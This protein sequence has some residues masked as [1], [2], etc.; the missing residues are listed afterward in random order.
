MATA[1]GN[2]PMDNSSLAN[3]QAWTTPI[4]NAFIAFGWLQT[5]DTGQAANP[6]AAVPS[7]AYAYWVFQ[8]ND[9]QAATSPIFVKV[10]IG[11]SATSPRIR[12]TV[13]TASNGSGTIT[14]Q[15]VSS[16]PWD[17]CAPSSYSS[18][19]A[20]QGGV[21]FP[22]YF[23]GD[24]GEFRMYI[25]QSTTIYSGLLF[26]IERSKDS[27]GNKTAEYFTVLAVASASYAASTAF[28]AQQTITPAGP[29]NL[30]SGFLTV[31]L[32]SGSNTGA[33]FGTV[34][35]LPIF[36]VIGKCGNPLLGLMSAC[37]NDISDGVVCTVNN[38]YG[39]THS[40]VSVKGVGVGTVTISQAFG[41]RSTNAANMGGLM[42][43]E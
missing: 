17:M 8:A 9:T 2:Y 20:N 40:I 32:T 24:A 1:T 38:M 3:F 14:G 26:V 41:L 11:Y 4:F 19:G 42:R 16:A 30:D 35:A 7:N 15:T 33:A 39:G 36:P 29:G 27:T 12:L 23:S 43:Y 25:W 37:A 21:T 6:P 28:R 34:A 10:E 31:P 22:C 13:G 18:L 5:A